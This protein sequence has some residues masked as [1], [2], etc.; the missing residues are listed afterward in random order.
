MSSGGGMKLWGQT[1]TQNFGTETG[2]YASYDG[3]T[4]FLPTPTSGTTWA[5]S[6]K[7]T[8]DNPP[9][10]LATAS[11]PLGT[12]GAYVRAVASSS[13]S[14]TKVSP[15]VGY[16]G[17]TEFYTSFK[18]LFGDASAGATASSGIWSFYQ[19]A[20]AN[21]SNA[22]DFTGSQT[23]TGLQFAFGA[24]GAID[25][26]YRVTSPDR[27]SSSILTLNSATVYKIEIIGNNKLSGTISY[28]YNG[29]SQTVAVQKFDLYIN[30]TKIGDDLYISNLPANTSINSCMFIG[31][32]SASNVANIFVDDVVV[33]NA[34]PSLIT[35]PLLYEDFAN[36]NATAT[37]ETT[38][39]SLLTMTDNVSL[40]SVS[41]WTGNKLYQYKADAPNIATVCLG[42]SSTDS[43]YLTTPAMDLSQPFNLTFKARSL[44][45]ATDGRFYVYLDGT[46]LIHSG[47][48]TGTTLTEYTTQTFV[49]TSSSK[50]TFTGRK[51]VGSEIIIDNI[52]VNNTNC[53]DCD[54]TVA[55]NAALT[56]NDDKTV[57][58]LTMTP[59]AK[60]TI[61]NDFTGTITD[62]ITL[63]S[64]ASGTATLIDYNSEP[65]INA[66]VQQYVTAGRN[67][68]MSTPINNTTDYSV[69][70]KGASVAEYNETTGLWPAVTSGTLTR[71]KGYVQVAGSTEVTTG[72]VNFTGTTNSG[73]VDI[74][75][76]NN[77]G[78]GKGFNLVGNPYPSYLSW[79]AVASN[80]INTN[81]TTGAK[82][83]TGTMW[84][85][86]I[87]YN[88]KSPWAANT[89]YTSGAVVY[90]GTRF[91]IATSTGT[92]GASG[93]PIGGVG[94]TGFADGDLTWDY[95]GSIYIFAT[96]N[97][98]GVPSSATVSNLIPPMQ[99]FWVKST[100]G[101]LTFTNSMRSHETVSN[102]LKAPKSSSSDMPFVR[103][104]VT[105]GV[106]ADEAVIYASTDASNS[107][108][109]YDAP[110]FFNTAGSN[111]PEIYTQ[112]VSE[113][114]VI[115]AMNE[116]SQ[117]TEI[118]L[119]FATEK[120]NDF[121]IS[122]T[123]F[124]N[125]KSDMQVMLKDKQKDT[126]FNLTSGQ[127]YVFSS[128][129]VN[130]AN[131]FSVIFRTSGSITGLSNNEKLNI[132]VF[133]NASNQIVVESPKKETVTIYN[134]MGQKQYENK[135]TSTKTTIN[136]V[137]GAGVYFV[138]LSIDGQSEIKKVVIR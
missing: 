58:S 124:R 36:Y 39:G 45:N 85:R 120:G 99:A 61:A 116:I 14:V 114:L 121:I 26:T 87:N 15:M 137:F 17:S 66:T 24:G 103:L 104:S 8:P 105:N 60:L 119:G 122:A 76:T 57:K 1:S 80:S 11:N 83:P 97:K 52:V 131:R 111:Q 78:G 77:S 30:G 110:K 129:I 49:G 117:G 10:V 33:Y 108:D 94:T 130:D 50:L 138:Q 100:G 40:A 106:S 64:D 75:L 63:Q 54:I 115:N 32:G 92:S 68:Y 69:L 74:A 132:Q 48:N 21:Y 123:E 98:S 101:T 55:K 16:T 95:A 81:V 113:K 65:T 18:I 112:I 22:N 13:T 91:Y 135:L 37:T 44:S 47:T 62:G 102:K 42:S 53:T 73:D 20:G 27:W 12:T 125:F 79:S 90:N 107:F 118:P 86:T 41:G 28:T 134:V 82:M 133:V 2:T 29:A 127:A 23:F 34:V 59:G 4:A 88:G 109:T 3:T 35:G 46:Q 93:G 38:L 136:K 31:E 71:G 51:V 19:G 43:A 72:T 6:G 126:E 128:E 56:L 67:W 7:N 25:L 70:N 5:R 9:I 96:V 89:L 84:Y